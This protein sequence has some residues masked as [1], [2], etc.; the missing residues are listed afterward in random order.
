MQFA[1]PRRPAGMVYIQ[2]FDGKLRDEC[3]Y[4]IVKRK[5]KAA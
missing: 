1:Q 3:G 4:A 5:Q 2:L